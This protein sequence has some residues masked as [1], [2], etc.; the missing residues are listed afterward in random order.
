MPYVT[1]FVEAQLFF[2]HK[3]VKVYHTYRRD[4]F[5][6]GVRDYWF[7]TD[8]EKGEEDPESFDI[9]ELSTWVKTDYRN[10]IAEG[11][12]EAALRAAID[13]GELTAPDPDNE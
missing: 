9:R 11:Y 7:V 1:T 5:E 8:P 3:N 2:E 13:S 12:R 10:S 4:E 6:N